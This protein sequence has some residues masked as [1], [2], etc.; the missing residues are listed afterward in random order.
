M[1]E[2]EEY[3]EYFITRNVNTSNRIEGSTLSY[4][5]T[6]AILWNDNSFTLNDIKPRDFY[7]AVNLKYAN[8]VMLDAIRRNDQ[9]T[10]ALIIHLNETINENIFDTSGYRQVLAKEISPAPM[11][12]R[13]RMLEI[14]EDFNNN[15][16]SPLLEKVAHFHIM[17]EHIHPFEH[18]N[19]KT[20]RLLINFKLINH[21]Q[22]PVIIPDERRE[23]YFN[24]ISEYD[25]Y[26]L[27]KMFSEIQIQEMEKI[28]K[29]I[30]ISM[31][32]EKSI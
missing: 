26:G 6:Y 17:F 11:E 7:E 16:R 4:I 2:S 23:E 12:V 31:Q 21:N 30:N 32:Q 19:G 8:S 20:A 5:E 28:E 9:L 24:Y 15:D 3:F 25:T 27:T 10:E 22:A 13:R 14:I 18:G 29:F 1:V